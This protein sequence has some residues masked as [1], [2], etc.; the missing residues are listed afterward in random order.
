MK[1]MA[2]ENKMEMKAKSTNTNIA[3]ADFLCYLNVASRM[4][5]KILPDRVSLFSQ[6]TRHFSTR[7]TFLIRKVSTVSMKI[8]EKILT[9]SSRGLM[10]DRPHRNTS[11]RILRYFAL[12]TN[13][14]GINNAGRSRSLTR[15]ATW[16]G[17]FVILLAL[18]V[19]DMTDLIRGIST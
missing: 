2:A 6:L 3:Y 8:S 16:L 18:T 19:S 11:G 1:K 10:P 13:I 14:E 17:V 9:Q 15:A 5:S 4:M 12:E 7:E